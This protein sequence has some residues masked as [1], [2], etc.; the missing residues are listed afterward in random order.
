M[1]VTSQVL[2]GTLPF[3]SLFFWEFYDSSEIGANEFLLLRS[4]PPPIR[5]RKW[6]VTLGV[7]AGDA[8]PPPRGVTPA[9]QGTRSW[10][11]GYVRRRSCSSPPARRSSAVS[12]SS[13]ASPDRR[14]LR[15]RELTAG[16]QVAKFPTGPKG[17]FI[18][19]HAQGFQKTILH[20]DICAQF[21]YPRFLLL[22]FAPCIRVSS[23]QPPQ[24]SLP[25]PGR[26]V[27]PTASSDP[28][29]SFGPTS[30]WAAARAPPPSSATNPSGS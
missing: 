24:S 8:I 19:D 3:P 13:R 26:A 25:F 15:F 18:P 7:T 17:G 1:S 4:A 28:P 16:R 10:R 14:P 5:T 30:A 22:F 11:C 27:A 6:S 12:T 9:S 21:H 2:L 29:S 23:L 20:S